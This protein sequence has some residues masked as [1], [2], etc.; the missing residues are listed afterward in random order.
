ML[1]WH[2]RGCVFGSWLV[3]QV[4]R[5]VGSINTV[6][7]AIR[8]AQGALL[9]RMGGATSQ[10]DLPSLVP[11]SVAGCGRLELGVPHWATSV[12]TASS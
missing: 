4:L 9:M 5:F 2:T 3:Q 7:Y 1:V 11:M 6:Q 10:L 12:I 8:G